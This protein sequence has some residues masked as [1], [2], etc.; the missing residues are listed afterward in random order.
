MQVSFLPLAAS[1]VH[2][3]TC[4]FV[5][6]GRIKML[7]FYLCVF[8]AFHFTLFIFPERLD[9]PERFV[10]EFIPYNLEINRHLWEGRLKD[11]SRMRMWDEDD[12]K[13]D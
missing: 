5:L 13:P 8:I 9:V 6:R 10:Q 4:S 12:F 2:V 3:S 11:V 1:R 7:I